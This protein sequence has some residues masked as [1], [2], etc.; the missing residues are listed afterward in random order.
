MKKILS[1]LSLNL[2]LTASI[3]FSPLINAGKLAELEQLN[4]LDKGFVGI[5]YDRKNDKIYLRIDNL[6]RQFIYQTSLPSGLGS[7]DIGLDRGQLGATRLAIF[8]RAGNRVFLKQLPTDFRAETKNRKEREAISEAFASSVLWGF[9]VVDSGNG[10]VLVDAS[11]FVLQDI[12]R[13]GDRLDSRKQGKGFK[14]DKSRSAIYMPR[15]T[16]FP[17]NTEL[18][19]TITLVGSKPG[20]Y[21]KQ[22]SPDDKTITLKMHHSF[23]RLPKAGYKPRKFLPKSGYWNISYQDYASPINQNLTKRFIGRHRL[24]KKNPE[25]QVSEAIEPIIYYLDPGVPEPVKSALID[26]AMWWNQA[27]EAIGYKDAFQV[28]ML[29]ANADP[30]DVRYNVIQWVH[31]ATRGWSYGSTVIDPRN[32]EIIKGHVTLGSLRVR[33]DYLIAQAMMAPFAQR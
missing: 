30:M 8:E 12:H 32:G 22:V 15:T 16:A 5:I 23:I 19:S 24:E 4:D 31:R 1:R 29:P 21:L 17:D 18:E 2:I 7:N 26:G 27:F 14:V 10:W 11:E 3:V 25:A 9:P 20:K 6:N 13:V 33:Q 28:K